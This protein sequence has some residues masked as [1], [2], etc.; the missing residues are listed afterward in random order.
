MVRTLVSA[1]GD[2][3]AGVMDVNRRAAKLPA[4]IPTL[5]PLSR[6]GCFL[7]WMNMLWLDHAIFRFFFNRRRKVTE[8][9]FRSSHPMPYQLRSAAA[10]GVRTVLSLRG[11]ETKIG[12]NRLEWEVCRTLGLTLIHFPLGSRDA[13]SADEVLGLRQ[14]FD[15][16]EYPVLV[17]CKSGAD[18]AGLVAALYL[19]MRE[20]QPVSEARKQLRFW[21]HGHVRQAKTGI[22]DHFLDCYEAESARAGI[23]FLDWVTYHYQR[24]AVRTSFREQWWAS[25]L[26][27][28]FLRRE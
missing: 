19:M 26:V 25:Q 18:R 5:A 17:H 22:L 13:P 20:G 21:W 8:G 24:D 2:K 3:Q 15:E 16:L 14:L 28:R 10:A 27:D 11:V 7:A 1:E 12:S 9:V 6:L 4:P 23:S